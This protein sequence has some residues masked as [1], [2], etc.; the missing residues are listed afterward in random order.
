MRVQDE[1][2]VLVE[3]EVARAVENLEK[4]NNSLGNAEKKIKPLD[5]ALANIKTESENATAGFDKMAKTIGSLAEVAAGLKALS[6]IKDMGAFALKT[7]DDFQTARNQF[8]T[9]LGDMKAGAGLFNEIKAFNDKTPF[10]LSTLTQ[11]A[12]VLAAAKV[13]LK[14]L[15]AQLTKF[16]DLAQ[17][18]SQKLTSYVNAFSQAAAKGKADMQVLNTYIHQGV[19]VLGALAK[20]FGVTTAEIVEMSSKGQ[21][22]FA[23]FSKAL[24]SL[25]AAGGQYFGGMELSSKSLAA[26]QEGLSEAV[27]SLAASFGEML[28][29]AGTSTLEMF[30]NLANAI[31]ES[32]IAKGVLA[33]ALIAVTG[34]MAAM[35][36]KSTAAFAAQM[37]LNF[38]VGAMNPAVMAATIAAA[39]I[40]AVYAGFSAQAQKAAREAEN[41]ALAQR[42]QNEAAREGGNT[43]EKYIAKIK[44]LEIDEVRRKIEEGWASIER[45]MSRGAS[46]ID[47]SRVRALEKEI[48]DRR[49]EFINELYKEPGED[50]IK[51]LSGVIELAHKFLL[52][53]EI[54]ISPEE[55][56]KLQA[57][58]KDATEGI[59]I[60]NAETTGW[61]K[62]LKSA[63]DFSDADIAAGLLDSG[64]AA[65]GEYAARLEAAEGR[66]LSFKDVLK[67]EASVLQ[68]TAGQWEKLLAAMAESGQW[69]Q[70][71]ES[72]QKVIDKLERAREAAG[73][74]GAGQTIEGL[75]KKIDD[76]GKSE[77]DL[78][79]EAALA[80]KALPEQAEEIRR[81]MQELDRKGML[82]EYNRQ[83]ENI[84]KSQNELAM[85]AYKAAGAA[86][87]E[88]AAFQEKLDL[89]DKIEQAER[90]REALAGIRDALASLGASA[91]L[92]GIE[93]FGSALGKGADA[94]DAM[95]Q[96]L[97]TMSQELLNA[98]PSMF[99][100]AG[101]QLICVPGQWP[102]GL[103]FIAASGASGLIKGWVN[104]RVESE[105]ESARANA[106]GNVFD[107]G[108]IRAF[109]RGGAFTNQIVESP[110]MFRFARGTG[111][112]G[113][114]GPEAVVPLRRMANGNLG[115]ET[116]GGGAGVTVKIINNS[117]AGVSA[118]ERE[119]GNGGREIDITIGRLVNSH[120][121]SGKADRAMARYG[122]RPAGV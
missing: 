44:G 70:A 16:G 37:S 47:F 50:K 121:A 66:A 31:N 41:L 15:Q 40:A 21:I 35:A 3:A 29:P 36:V 95:K 4:F 51:Q 104:G 43:L 9:L 25:A 122:L 111:L 86:E 87:D 97:V 102:L 39:G 24:D 77:Y 5:K 74:A 72:I 80:N 58:I 67:D 109:A 92:S 59:K 8:G 105:R 75:Q 38:A 76:L 94:G 32:P 100:Q 14:D 23:D 114:A 84:G 78:A 7:A 110:V 89:R 57:I 73:R 71:E 91:A 53:V 85:A 56:A 81:L 46:R 18:N 20:N 90:L 103:A 11:A 12:N 26:M 48:L 42:K 99:L 17:G 88:I 69:G 19:P 120:I 1:L 79:Y 108:G 98:L 117:G 65:I 60:L 112:M 96:A 93:A 113:E 45:L 49:N 34:Y 61:K 115:V 116:Q 6:V 22:A 118:E 82:E 33:G 62:T 52:D 28:L 64:A 10:D 63:M 101:L 13:P 119:N 54:G 83:I 30:T 68:N 2:R 55:K 106:S 27:K 107:P